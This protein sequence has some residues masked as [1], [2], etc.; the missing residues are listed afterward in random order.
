[1]ATATTGPLLNVF[2]IENTGPGPS[3]HTREGVPSTEPLRFFRVLRELG[4]TR[5]RTASQ[6]RRCAV[7]DAT[8]PWR[9]VEIVLGVSEREDVIVS[10]RLLM[11]ASTHFVL[12]HVAYRGEDEVLT[13]AQAILELCL[14]GGVEMPGVGVGS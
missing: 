5:G 3:R 7:E 10:V 8:I 9:A 4:W 14:C 13:R 12:S 2:I 1:L 6:H 11:T